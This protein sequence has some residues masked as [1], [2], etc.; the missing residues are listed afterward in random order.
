MKATG[1]ELKKVLDH[2][3]EKYPDGARSDKMAEGLKL[4]LGKVRRCLFYAVD[5]GWVVLTSP[6]AENYYGPYRLTGGGIDKLN[7]WTGDDDVLEI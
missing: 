2:L 1:E 7:H 5:K 4:D 3:H 6:K